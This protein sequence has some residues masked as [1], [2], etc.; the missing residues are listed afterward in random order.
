VKQGVDQ[1]LKE[2]LGQYG[3][4]AVSIGSSSSYFVSYE[5]GHLDDCNSDKIGFEILIF[6]YLFILSKKIIY[7]KNKKF[8]FN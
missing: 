6:I 3:P 7:V 8:S 5:K 1:A 4:V 2:V